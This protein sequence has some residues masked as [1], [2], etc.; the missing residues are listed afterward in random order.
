MQ[1]TCEQVFTTE[2]ME[3]YRVRLTPPMALGLERSIYLGFE[4]GAAIGLGGGCPCVVMTILEHRSGGGA[5]EHIQ[6]QQ[7]YRKKGLGEE[8]WRAVEAH[9]GKLIGSFGGPKTSSGRL[10]KRL[11]LDLSRR[12]RHDDEE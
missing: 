2:R 5:V 9:I 3:V 6:T 10:A 4:R 8:L 11:G 12:Q 1:P 7:L